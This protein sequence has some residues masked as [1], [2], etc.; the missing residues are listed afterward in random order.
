M[1]QVRASY[2]ER[3][4]VGLGRRDAMAER[5]LWRRVRRNSIRAAVIGATAACCQTLINR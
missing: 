3:R 4:E 1:E 5:R 2:D